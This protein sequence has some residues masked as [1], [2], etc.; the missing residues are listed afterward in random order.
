MLVEAFNSVVTEWS[1][2]LLYAFF[3]HDNY[4]C[5]LA[6]PCVIV[7]RE[8]MPDGLRGR[9]VAGPIIFIMG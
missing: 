4:H 6:Y 5:I 9:K 1:F 7:S 2:N 3:P 8:A